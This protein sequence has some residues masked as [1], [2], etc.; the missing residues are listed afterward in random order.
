[1]IPSIG[2]SNG[3]HATI[4][5][6]LH[7]ERHNN[8]L[9]Y[10]KT[11]KKSKL[12][13]MGKLLSLIPS[14][15][16]RISI[17]S[18]LKLPYYKS[19]VIK[20]HPPRWYKETVVNYPPGLPPGISKYFSIESSK[21]DHKETI[22]SIL[23]SKDISWSTQTDMQ[24]PYFTKTL[25]K[26]VEQFKTT[27]REVDFFYFY[28]ADGLGHVNGVDS[29]ELKNY[30]KKVDNKVKELIKTNDDFFIFSDHGMVKINDFINV[31]NHLDKSSLRL[32]KDYVVFYDAT[33]V[34]FWVLNKNKEKELLKIIS[35]IPK[36]TFMTKKL[37]KRYNLNFKNNKWFDYMLLMDPGV[38]PF[39]DYFIP[40]KWGIK[41]YHGYWPEHPDSK[42]IF[43]TNTFKTKKKE[44]DIVD[45][46]PTILKAMRLKK[47][48]PE[49]I[50]GEPIN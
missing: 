4:W 16:V 28:G 39:P 20:R 23:S 33:M 34:R 49:G 17:L 21:P 3:A 30:L 14:Y 12:G 18:A 11:G 19:K 36:T 2:D 43:I 31:K 22:F 24:N 1:M 6:G 32:G 5:S 25:P 15:W 38:R 9:L 40:V 35:K 50:D 8:F 45:I 7:Q 13:S 42:G 10:Y 47:E 27:G 48:I 46:M 29:E 44:I 37:L 26:S 41:A